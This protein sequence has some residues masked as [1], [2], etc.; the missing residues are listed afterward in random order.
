LRTEPIVIKVAHLL[1]RQRILLFC[2]HAGLERAGEG[3]E[4]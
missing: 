2:R 4:R 3:G 1:V